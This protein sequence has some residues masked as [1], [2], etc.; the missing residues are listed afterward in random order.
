M[1]R[2]LTITPAKER[3]MPLTKNHAFGIFVCVITCLLIANVLNYFFGWQLPAILTG[4]VLGLE[5]GFWTGAYETTYAVHKKLYCPFKLVFGIAIYVFSVWGAYTLAMLVNY[6]NAL[7]T[8][9]A[10][11]QW[12]NLAMS[13]SDAKLLEILIGLAQVGIFIGGVVFMLPLKILQA[14]DDHSVKSFPRQMLILAGL[15]LFAGAFLPFILASIIAGVVFA[16]IAAI[17]LVIIAVIDLSTK[18]ETM[19]IAFGGTIGSLAGIAVG[20]T[21]MDFQML[22]IAML[23]G[24]AIGLISGW[25]SPKMARLLH[26]DTVIARAKRYF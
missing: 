1:N 5:A 25:L 11:K 21:K 10:I 15:M 24:S 19:S 2:S 3:V 7:G 20:W 12:L 9:T 6:D 16:A 13:Q 8:M 18:Y 4:L 22:L 23:F 26:S 17:V 14:F